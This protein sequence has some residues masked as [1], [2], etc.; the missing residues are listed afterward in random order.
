M[1]D[2]P[3][4]LAALQT[5]LADNTVGAISAQDV[6]DL[7][8]SVYDAN[9]YNVKDYGALG[10]GSTDDTTAIEDTF[11]AAGTHGLVYFPPVAN[12][13]SG[14]YLYSGDGIDAAQYNIMGAGWNQSII[15]LDTGKYLLTPSAALNN[16]QVRY[17]QVKNGAGLYKQTFTGVSSIRG[18]SFD[19]VWFNGYSTCAVGSLASDDPYMRFDNC[20]FQGLKDTSIGVAINGDISGGHIRGCAFLRNRY[21]IKL[22]RAG[23]AFRIYDND[24]IR[25]DAYVS[26]PRVDIWLVPPSATAVNAGD[27]CTIT[28]NKF[29][30]ENL[31][32]HDFKI[33]CAAEDTTVTDFTDTPHD[34]TTDSADSIRGLLVAYNN[35]VGSTGA[36]PS[37]VYTTVDDT[38][39][40]IIGPNYFHGTAPSYVLEFLNS[41][42]KTTSKTWFTGN[43]QPTSGL[44]TFSNR[45]VTSL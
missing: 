12:Q 23:L 1:A 22:G 9:T 26:T 41:S 39:G 40:L 3:R 30:N 37:L 6:R 44:L 4:T 18:G 20:I 35:S 27:G 11:T 29:G 21:H 16:A 7:L 13:S 43:I 8:V 36:S 38:D 34:A 14:G 45:S 5:L 19:H 17:L 32:S 2:T 15:L 33:L 42:A 28:H 10:D 24:F 31:N 25:S